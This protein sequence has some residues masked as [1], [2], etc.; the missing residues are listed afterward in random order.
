M[1]DP[2][3][4]DEPA[5]Q[6]GMFIPQRVVKNKKPSRV[7]RYAVAAIAALFVVVGSSGFEAIA[8]RLAPS[9]NMASVPQMVVTSERPYAHHVIPAGPSD[10]FND[11]TLYKNFVTTA[12]TENNSFLALD[13]TN[14]TLELVIE[15]QGVLKVNITYLPKE[16]SWQ[17]L[18]P[19]IYDVSHK[20]ERQYS[21]LEEVYYPH[22]VTIADRYLIHGIPETA[23]GVQSDVPDTHGFLLSNSD[24]LA[25]YSLIPEDTPIY[26]HKEIQAPGIAASYEVYGERLDEGRYLV[27]DINSGEILLRSDE[28][29]TVLSIASLTK[30]MT[31][32]I[33]TEEMSI[34]SEIL[35]E[36][37]MYVDT[38]VP[39]LEAFPRATLFHL[40]QV[41]LVESSNEA[42]EA[43]ATQVSGSREVFI[44]Q[45]NKKAAELGMRNTTF[46]DP[47]GLNEGNT[48]SLEDLFIL[49]EYLYS[50]QRFLLEISVEKNIPTT[51]RVTNFT[52]LQNFNTVEGVADIIG[53]KIG[54]TTAAKQTSV[55]IHSRT[56]SNGVERPIAIIVLGSN[57]RGDDVRFIYDYFNE[58][59]K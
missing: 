2:E 38:L 51:E 15:G 14:K 34:D 16:G 32:I 19:G 35:L 54:E 1:A 26:V 30:L 50:E 17:A 3:Y 13:Q 29:D 28:V 43:I 33:A 4:T 45:M 46:T 7:G 36:A 5:F 53:G 8:S 12:Q 18:A 58:R 11:A 9:S 59:F 44:A 40:L 41:L 27:G 20:T 25:L 55:T 23:N 42:A 48:S 57:S 47:S 52:S 21:V 49:A 10:Y 39:R 31:A 22:V 56:D 6:P 24:A 37:E